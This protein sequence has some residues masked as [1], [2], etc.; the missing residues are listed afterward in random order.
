MEYKEILKCYKSSIMEEETIEN[1][2]AKI[3][4]I[5]LWYQSRQLFSLVLPDIIDLSEGTNYLNK[6]STNIHHQIICKDP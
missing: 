2:F 1:F 4:I 5:V 3:I 6:P